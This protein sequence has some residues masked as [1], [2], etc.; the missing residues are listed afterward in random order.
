[1]RLR[2]G[3]FGLRIGNHG[4]AVLAGVALLLLPRGAGAQV[5]HA[6]ETSPYHDLRAKQAASFIG[7]FLSG[8]RGT[9]GVSPFRGPVVGIRYDR[10]VG[11]AAEVLIGISGA[12]L[13]HYIVDATQPL[14][15]R[16][17]GPVKG[18]LIFMETGF[19]LIVTGRKSWHGFVPYVGGMLGVAF[20]TSLGTFNEFT[21]GTR[22]TVTPHVGLKWFPVQALAFKVEAR[23][24]IWRVKYPEPWFTPQSTDGEPVLESGR[25][26]AAEW[27]HH[28]TLMISL[29]YTFAY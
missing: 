18:D 6:P 28:P 3:D 7:G 2:I 16:T 25:D 22:G 14:A 10:Q 23:D 26:K 9:P 11:T 19:S 17:T 8:Q 15:T 29:G 27:L 24:V 1:M 13:D 5:G 20:E 12:H 4:I 21:F